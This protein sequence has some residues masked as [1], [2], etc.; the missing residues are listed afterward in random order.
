VAE[1]NQVKN[2][3]GREITVVTGYDPPPIPGWQ[4]SAWYA[5]VDGEEER[6]G[7]GRGPD[8]EAAID[9]L[10]GWIDLVDDDQ[11]F[12]WRDGAFG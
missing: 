9:S 5:Y 12:D 7:E 3:A 1:R 11:P 6:Y 4:D 2:I 8:K 10:L